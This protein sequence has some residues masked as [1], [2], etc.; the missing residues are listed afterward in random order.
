MSTKEPRS[1]TN[2]NAKRLVIVRHAHRDKPMGSAFDNGIS[3]KGRKQAKAIV[4]LYRER[5]DDEMALIYS[6]PKLRCIETVEPLASKIASK[7]VPLDLLIESG[8]EEGPE[9]LVRRVR[10]FCTQWKKE[11]SPIVI[12]C[13]HG[14]WI[15]VFFQELVGTPI[16]LKKGAWAEIESKN[17]ETKLTW[18]VQEPLIV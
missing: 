17:G 1:K 10:Q 18:I 11:S 3:K 7:I 15:P 2:S 14:D 5:F 9:D 13:S 8:P 16:D 6:S 12:A 4:K